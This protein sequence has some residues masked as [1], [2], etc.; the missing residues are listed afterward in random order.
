MLIPNNINPDNQTR[1]TARLGYYD[2]FIDT[3]PNLH[4]ATSVHVFGV[5]VDAPR[6]SRLR[7]YPDGLWISGVQVS[8]AIFSSSFNIPGS[9]NQSCTGFV[10]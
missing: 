1:S 6:R 2:G 8:L 5:I 10:K 7:D 9:L 3:R 4:V